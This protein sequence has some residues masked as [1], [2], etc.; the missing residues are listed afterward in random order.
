MI[1]NIN[2]NFVDIKLI[3]YSQPMRVILEVN[4]V[5]VSKEC[6]QIL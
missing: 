2:M 1:I 6:I 4:Y 3:K 5:L